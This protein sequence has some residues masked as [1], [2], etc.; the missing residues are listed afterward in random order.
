[1]VRLL[2]PITIHKRHLFFFLIQYDRVSAGQGKQKTS[3]A[4]PRVR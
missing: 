1:M 4:V 3:A 2:A